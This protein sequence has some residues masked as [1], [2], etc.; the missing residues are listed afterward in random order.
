VS[1]SRKAALRLLRAA[2][3]PTAVVCHNELLAPGVYKA[4]RELGL[5]IPDDL[6]VVGFG[7]FVVAQA[8]EPEL[9]TV[10]IPNQE[11]GAAATE[12]LISVVEGSEQPAPTHLTLM[13]QLR[14]RGSTAPATV[15]PSA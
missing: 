14:V 10:A 13:G 7:D 15:R 9:T 5:H 1:D 8:L 6:S 3:R 4:A 2:P 11:M 12:L